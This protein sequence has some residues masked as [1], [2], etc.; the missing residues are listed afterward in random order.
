[1]I[2]IPNFIEFGL[3]FMLNCVTSYQI[4]SG[5]NIQDGGS[6]LYILK[7]FFFY[8]NIALFRFFMVEV[9]IGI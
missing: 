1:M 4:Q 2:Q 9:R 5:R 8:I 3:L 7:I 6:E